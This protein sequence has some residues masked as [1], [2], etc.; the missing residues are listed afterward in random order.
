M[1]DYF[2]YEL[3]EKDFIF[4]GDRGKLY[5]IVRDS[6][7]DAFAYASIVGQKTIMRV[8]LRNFIKVPEEILLAKY[9]EK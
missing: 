6:H 2:G 8:Y 9:L 7:S 3:H 1:K 4:G 5:Q